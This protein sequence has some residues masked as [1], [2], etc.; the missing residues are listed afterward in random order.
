MLA[1]S[2]DPQVAEQQMHAIIFYLTTFG[3]IDGDFDASEKTFVKDYVARLVAHRVDGAK[4]AGALRDELVAKY[5]THFH[6]VFHQIDTGVR[7]LFTEAVAKDEDLEGFVTSKLKLRCFEIFKGFDEENQRALM[8]TCD[9]LIAADGQ[10]HPAE[11]RFRA[12]LA[13]L[14][15]SEI[16][17]DEAELEAIEPAHVQVAPPATPPPPPRL[18]NHPFF[19]RLEKHYSRD[20]EVIGRQAAAD[21]E[22]VERTMAKL[23]EMRREGEGR[24]A[25]RQRVTE[26]APGEAFL[27]GHV[28]VRRPAA[29]RGYDLTVL[30]DLHGCYSCLKAAILQSDFF[31]KVQAY[32]DDPAARPYPLLVLLGDYI[33]RGQYSYNGV[34]R[35]IMQLF[36]TV[37]EHVVP[38]RGNHEYYLEYKGKIY[39]GVRPAEA[40]ATLEPYMPKEQFEAYMRLFDALPN[41]LLFDRTLFV[42]AGIPRDELLAERWKDLSS[43][44]DPDVRFQMLWSDPSE[45]DFVPA[46]LQK[47][48][49]RFPFG[50][51][52]FRSFMARLGTNCMVRGHEK[53]D[54]GFKKVYDDGVVVLLNLFS[55]GGATNDDLP[56]DSSYRSVT[57]M[58]LTV[59]HRDGDATCVP[60]ELD[61]ERYNSPDRN[62]F[63]RVP[64]EIE[65]KAS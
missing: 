42:H 6:E 3:Y 58:A 8:A 33:D 45:A 48:N 23:D 47:K 41:M 5:T 15:G 37:P 22:L 32:K 4:V 31:A 39:G 36:L 43:L 26:F 19:E 2:D 60:W 27:D 12:E 63:F 56:P 40:I 57:P 13:A 24:L 65:F 38:L 17:L 64:P 9:E 7:A 61:Y 50:R 51:L 18:E 53:V 49:A 29:G 28:F 46:E 52:Q 14:L 30:G 21:R 25:G 35:T 11:A 16:P 20:P 55:S 34:L 62:A 54:A 1:F 59:R 10:V 44:N